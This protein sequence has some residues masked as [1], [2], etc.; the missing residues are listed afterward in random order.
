VSAIDNDAVPAHLVDAFDVRRAI[1]AAVKANTA[2]THAVE[3]AF[4]AEVRA[5]R[6]QGLVEPHTYRRALA[7]LNRAIKPFN[8][9]YKP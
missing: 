5:A 6:A 2:L 1:E 9:A 8:E 3:L 7:V 4:Y